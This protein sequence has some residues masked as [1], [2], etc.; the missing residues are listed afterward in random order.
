[1]SGVPAEFT[2]PVTL[3]SELGF[4]PQYSAAA[5]PLRVAPTKTYWFN[6][7]AVPL[8]PVVLAPL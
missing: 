6:V 1:V 3:E 2:V 5:V 8:I 4:V 7:W